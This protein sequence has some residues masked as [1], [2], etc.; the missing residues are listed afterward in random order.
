M[1]LNCRKQQIIINVISSCS[2]SILAGIAIVFLFISTSSVRLQRIITADPP[3]TNGL[4]T[5]SYGTGIIHAEYHKLRQITFRIRFK[6]LSIPLH[7]P[8]FA[9]I[10]FCLMYQ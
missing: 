10:S 5:N 9:A 2:D 6:W 1:W 8:S 4:C 7:T 3:F